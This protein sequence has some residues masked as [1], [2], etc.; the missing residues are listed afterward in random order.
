MFYAR[1]K[2]KIEILLTGKKIKDS[3][4][5]IKLSKFNL[6]LEPVNFII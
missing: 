6:H 5:K 1:I 3:L 4:K 2:K